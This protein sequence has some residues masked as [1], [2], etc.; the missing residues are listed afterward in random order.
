M[1]LDLRLA[2]LADVRALD[3]AAPHRDP[4][5]D[6]ADSIGGDLD[7]FN[8]GQR[9]TRAGEGAADV[10]RYLERASAGSPAA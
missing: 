7:A 8:Q 5:A 6:E 1:T 4:W 9:G 2:P 10:R 3:L